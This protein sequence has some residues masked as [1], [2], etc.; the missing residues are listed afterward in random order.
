MNRPE[1]DGIAEASVFDGCE[2]PQTADLAAGEG[3]SCAVRDFFENAVFDS[4]IG[5]NGAAERLQSE[6]QEFQKRADTI[7]RGER[8]SPAASPAAS[9]DADDPHRLE[10]MET[11]LTRRKRN[12]SVW[13]RSE[14]ALGKTAGELIEHAAQHDQATANLLREVADELEAA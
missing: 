1:I 12:L 5:R 13:M 10:K 7:L 6:T 9:G 4:A 2:F 11:P 8:K 14:F 3:A